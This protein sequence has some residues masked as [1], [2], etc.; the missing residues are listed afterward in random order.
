[1]P[2]YPIFLIVNIDLSAAVV[3]C[4][5]MAC[6]HIVKRRRADLL[7]VAN[8]PACS[9]LMAGADHLGIVSVQ[10][11]LAGSRRWPGHHR[12]VPAEVSISPGS[13]HR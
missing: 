11:V 6:H 12:R 9:L 7:L 8:E 5:G 10:K 1:V 2:V 13:D 4:G 3:H